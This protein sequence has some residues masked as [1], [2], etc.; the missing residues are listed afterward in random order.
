MNLV[1][2][3]LLVCLA[4]ENRHTSA[5]A[6]RTHSNTKRELV[7]EFQE[8]YDKFYPTLLR[9]RSNKASKKEIKVRYQCF[10][11][12]KKEVDEVN[13]DNS[14]PYE[15]EINRFSL[16]TD[17]ERKLFTGFN[18]TTNRQQEKLMRKYLSKDSKILQSS[19]A[20]LESLDWIDK[21]AN[22]PI[23]DQSA[24]GSCGSCWAFSAVS[25]MEAA[26]FIATGVLINFSDL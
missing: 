15:A 5:Y 16:M 25:A 11:K 19:L 21:G 6:K 20:Y 3:C 26:Y 13:G 9:Q 7:S 22:P 4:T 12:S 23:K 14:I 17:E 2:L 18:V 10:V 1:F 24:S 8:Y